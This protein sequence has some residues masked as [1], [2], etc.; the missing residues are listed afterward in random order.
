MVAVTCTIF[1]AI[2][3]LGCVECNS[4]SISFDQLENSDLDS[5]PADG[6][7]Q[8]SYGNESEHDNHTEHVFHVVVIEFGRVM[9]PYVI[10]LWIML[11]SLAK[12]GE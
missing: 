12:I 2:G 10:S 4:D 9:T 3:L 5:D 1:A 8:Y 6:H 7:T 11:A